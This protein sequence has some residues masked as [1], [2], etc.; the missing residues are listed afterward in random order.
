[1]S[2]QWRT[3]FTTKDQHNA[4]AIWPGQEQKRKQ[5]HEMRLIRAHRLTDAYNGDAEQMQCTKE[6]HDRVHPGFLQL[7]ERCDII[8][9]VPLVD[10]QRIE[11]DC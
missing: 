3:L 10:H 8:G 2:D 9:G 1:M 4:H 11:H 7:A 5:D 6:K